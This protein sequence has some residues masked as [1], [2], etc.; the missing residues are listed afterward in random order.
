MTTQALKWENKW[1]LQNLP[2]LV[3]CIM[4]LLFLDFSADG[5]NS[6]LGQIWL[7]SMSLHSL[8]CL[9]FVQSS[10]W[11]QTQ[12]LNSEATISAQCPQKPLV[13]LHS[14]IQLNEPL[15]SALL[16]AVAKSEPSQMSLA[17][18]LRKGVLLITYQTSP[19]KQKYPQTFTFG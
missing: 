9:F 19:E 17:F 6:M 7:C 16:N 1:S 5:L 10:K 11:S 4:L 8:L 2:H 15:F 14:C 18:H 12:G 13:P 3:L